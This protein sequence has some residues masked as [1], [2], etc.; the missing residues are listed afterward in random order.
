MAVIDY[1]S[2]KHAG[3]EERNS[4]PRSGTILRLGRWASGKKRQDDLFYEHGHDSGP[5]SATY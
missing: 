5:V 1:L 4:T 2:G 3:L